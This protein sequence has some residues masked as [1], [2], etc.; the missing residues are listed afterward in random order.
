MTPLWAVQWA[1]KSDRSDAEREQDDRDACKTGGW[2]LS[3]HHGSFMTRVRV[4][5]A[6]TGGIAASWSAGM[7]LKWTA[8]VT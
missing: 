1:G 6:M 5:V 3:G 2:W 8:S 4:L 7:G